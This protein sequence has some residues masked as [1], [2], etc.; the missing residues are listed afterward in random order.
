MPGCSASPAISPGN[1]VPICSTLARPSMSVNEISPRLPDARTMTSDSAVVSLPLAWAFSSA[2]AGPSTTSPSTTRLRVAT[3]SSLPT[4]LSLSRTASVRAPLR[5]PQPSDDIS[6]TAISTSA[7]ISESTRSLQRPVVALQ[8]RRAL[9]L[10]VVGEDHHVIRPWCFVDRVLEAGEL[11]VEP[12]QRVERGRCE[13]PGVVGD[14]VVADEVGVRRRDATVDVAHQGVDREISQRRGGRGSQQWVDPASL[15]PGLDALTPGTSPVDHL[16]PRIS[17][18][19]RDESAD[20][21]RIGQE[22]VGGV[23]AVLALVE[24]RAERD[25][26]VGA[27]TGE[28]VRP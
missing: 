7:S 28:H 21:I 14:F 8:E 23:V 3:A 6:G 13:Q 26:R 25:R 24:Q 11:S 15:Q 5:L 12:P 9:G 22:V 4:R 16:A 20:G 17:E 2:N 18:R 10:A 19:Q 1:R 27:V